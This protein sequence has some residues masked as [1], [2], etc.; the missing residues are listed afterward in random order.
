MKGS[1]RSNWDQRS[2]AEP[3]TTTGKRVARKWFLRRGKKWKVQPSWS[4]WIIEGSRR[5][6]V[7]F[8]K[9]ETL[10]L[11]KS[12][13]LNPVEI[14]AAHHARCHPLL[15]VSPPGQGFLN[16]GLNKMH[17]RAVNEN[18]NMA[19]FRQRELDRRQ[20]IEGVRIVLAQF[21]IRRHIGDNLVYRRRPLFRG[22]AWAGEC[23]RMKTQGVEEA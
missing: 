9:D 16:E 12:A 1:R 15:S 22:E 6:G 20:G 8:N 5:R 18:L 7:Y 2:V 23:W 10:G 17:K 4:S 11:D 14:D 19:R 21:K 3:P 13:G